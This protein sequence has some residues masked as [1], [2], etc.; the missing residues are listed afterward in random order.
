VKINRKRLAALAEITVEAEQCD[1]PVKGNISAWDEE[2]DRKAEEEINRRLD[3]GDIWAWAHVIVRASYAGLDA[4][5]SLG[6]CNY[7]D[8]A[9]FR[10]PG[11][12]FDDMRATVIEDLAKA[13]EATGEKIKELR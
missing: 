13:L 4:T 9:D 11:G 1:I 2:T 8:E 10:A 7:R 12:Y 6:G 3:G 5:E